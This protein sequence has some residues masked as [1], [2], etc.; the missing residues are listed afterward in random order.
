MKEYAVEVIE[1]KTIVSKAQ[2]FVK[3]EDPSK[4]EITAKLKAIQEKVLYR[5]TVTVDRKVE[6]KI[7]FGVDLN[8]TS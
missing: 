3:S 6:V 7:I 1:V 2:I 5:D 4:A 8:G